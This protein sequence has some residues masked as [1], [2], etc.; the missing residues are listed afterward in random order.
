MCLHMSMHVWRGGCTRGGFLPVHWTHLLQPQSSHDIGKSCSHSI[1]WFESHL[2]PLLFL[3]L[4]SSFFSSFTG[5]QFFYHESYSFEV[6]IQQF[7]LHL[8]NFLNFI[9]S[10]H[11]H[12]NLAVFTGS[13]PV[14]WRNEL[15]VYIEGSVR[16]LRWL[17]GSIVPKPNPQAMTLKGGN[18]CYVYTI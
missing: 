4:C 7:L 18:Y 13:K 9:Q 1:C 3:P 17:A 10:P 6:Y 12:L 16:V 15:T 11:P 5:S 8:R 14:K 2:S